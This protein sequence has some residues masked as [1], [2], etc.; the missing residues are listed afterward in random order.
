MDEFI[1]HLIHFLMYSLV[2]WQ[3]VLGVYILLIWVKKNIKF[4][5]NNGSNSIFIDSKDVISK[6][7]G[8]IKNKN[9][10]PVEVDYKKDIFV[11]KADEIKIKSEVKKG[12][13][14]TQKN[15]LKELRRS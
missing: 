4:S 8:E 12:K 2:L 6:T 14:K 13:V 5:K 7:S 11:D 9:T 10:G 3:V 1:H 15:K